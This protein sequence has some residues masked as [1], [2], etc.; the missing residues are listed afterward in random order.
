E[1]EREGGVAGVVRGWLAGRIFHRPTGGYVAVVNVGMDENWL[2]HPFAMA[3]LYA[4]GR[5]AWNANLSASQIAEEWTRLT[6]GNDPV[7]VKTATE[8]ATNSWRAYEKYTGF[9]GTQTLTDITGSHYG[10]NIESSEGN[11]WGQ[12]HRADHEGIGMDRSVKT[13]TG[14]SGQYRPAVA[15]RYESVATTPDEL[16]LFFHHVPYTHLLHSGTTVIQY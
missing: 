1:E 15:N 9:L 14:F 7:V 6:F 5:L 4:Y 8:I 13:G 2:A 16:L 10:P 11:G 12:W 3:N